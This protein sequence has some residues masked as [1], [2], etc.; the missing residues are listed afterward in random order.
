[1]KKYYVQ[2][3]GKNY[4]FVL[5]NNELLLFENTNG[6]LKRIKTNSIQNKNEILQNALSG[7]LQTFEEEINK[8]IKNGEYS[9]IDEVFKDIK[10]II[11][12][13][14]VP[15]FNTLISQINFENNEQYKEMLNRISKYFN[16]LNLEKKKELVEEKIDI[17]LQTLFTE[18]G[19]KEYEISPSK[20]VITYEKDGVMYTFNNTNSNQTVYD[21]V[22]QNIEFD[23]MNSREQID[24]EIERIMDL[25]GT[26][27]YEENQNVD[28]NNLED[29][30]KTIADFLKKEY[31]Y[32]NIKGIK[33]KNSNVIDGGWTVET[34]DGEIIPIFVT[35]D[36]NGKL[37]VTFGKE[38]QINSKDSPKTETKQ[39]DNDS[40][41]IEEE[42][43]RQT[44]EEQL[45]D[46][47][48]RFIYDGQ[49]LTD[50]DI[51]IIETY[52]NNEEEFNKLSE[53][54]QNLCQEILEQ[55]N[56]VKEKNKTNARQYK[57][58]PPKKTNENG[59]VYIGVVTFISGLVTGLFVF[60]FFK[61]FI[62]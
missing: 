12:N 15:E 43:D 41:K 30:E 47:Y 46:I 33:P 39:M 37:E 22:L 42:I 13:I 3:D 58:E 5:K 11:G 20:S 49:N 59:M 29:Y 35:K 32:T 10:N 54:G 51:K 23:K 28:V 2:I 24:S 36:E 61:W 60:L 7:L 55:Y 52:I 40:K 25:E 8:K 18:N 62:S 50:E 4:L 21:T 26:H 44:K 6:N 56:K 45:I 19:I 38:K 1:M 9:N 57:L 48:T 16:E 17:N 14:N 31:S 53:N 27:K 34:T